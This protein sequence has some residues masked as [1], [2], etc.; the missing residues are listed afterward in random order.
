MRTGG[1]SFDSLLAR[2]APMTQLRPWQRV[3]SLLAVAAACGQVLVGQR[4]KDLFYPLVRTADGTLPWPSRLLQTLYLPV[5]ITMVVQL[6]KMN[7]KTSPDLQFEMQR[8]TLISHSW[9]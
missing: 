2:A 6:R 7:C 5:M 1:R 4:S 8:C 3:M 9:L